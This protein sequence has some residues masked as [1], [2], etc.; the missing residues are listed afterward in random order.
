MHVRPVKREEEAGD[1]TSMTQG[2]AALPTRPTADPYS[3]G[4]AIDVESLDD[5]LF[6][7]DDDGDSH[8]SSMATV[9]FDEIGASEDKTSS[10]S[11]RLSSSFLLRFGEMYDNLLRGGAFCCPPSSSLS[12]T[13]H[14]ISIS[15]PWNASKYRHARAHEAAQ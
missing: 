4:V 11:C 14:N 3:G 5:S 9:N 12:I 8:S 7:P 15:F 1:V 6:L 10:C 2:N 13:G